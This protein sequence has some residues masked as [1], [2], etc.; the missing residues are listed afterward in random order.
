MK[1]GTH[2]SLEEYRLQL[3]RCAEA[4]AVADNATVADYLPP[5]DSPALV[6]LFTDGN[7]DKRYEKLRDQLELLS[8]LPD[9]DARIENYVRS[10]PL[11]AYA[12]SVRDADRF[13]VW[14]ERR[15]MFT[16]GQRDVVTCLHARHQIEFLAA[17]ARSRHLHFQDLSSV[18]EELRTEFGA[19][20]R[21]RIEINPVHQFARFH[22]MALFEGEEDME[23]PVSAVLFPVETDI[24]TVVLEDA[25]LWLVNA[26]ARKGRCTHGELLP[27]FPGSADELLDVCSDLIDVG[28]AA[29]S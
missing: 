27:R 13:L 12:T 23:L 3:N 15:H 14:L 10:V 5:G 9:L 25:G 26:L 11:D 20:N 22:T 2:S 17:G 6:D 4:M 16:P 21:I 24:R 19:N 7:I 8:D 28:M 1:P 18:S 29:C